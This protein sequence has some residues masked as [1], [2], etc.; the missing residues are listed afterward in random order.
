MGI[1]GIMLSAISYFL[2]EIFCLANEKYI[3]F[4]IYSISFYIFGWICLALPSE[5]KMKGI[6]MVLQRIVY[7][8]F[9]GICICGPLVS[10]EYNKYPNPYLSFYLGS[11]FIIVAACGADAIRFCISYIFHR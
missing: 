8:F 7:S 4:L 5:E 9:T 10:F 3:F 1:Y 11:I 2:T 6:K